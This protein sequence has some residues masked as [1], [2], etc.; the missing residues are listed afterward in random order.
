VP[1]RNYIPQT[2][3]GG[4]DLQTSPGSV[5]VTIRVQPVFSSEFNERSKENYKQNFV[6][7]VKETWENKCVLVNGPNRLKP[8]FEINFTDQEPHYIAMVD[9]NLQGQPSVSALK[10]KLSGNKVDEIPK[11]AGLPRYTYLPA[12]IVQKPD[13]AEG[14]KDGYPRDIIRSWYEGLKYFVMDTQPSLDHCA[15]SIFKEFGHNKTLGV[16]VNTNTQWF[17]KKYN[18]I[19]SRIRVETP[20]SERPIS[21]LNP[22]PY[23]IVTVKL[24]DAY[25]SDISKVGGPKNV[26]LPEY[27]RK[28]QNT[29]VPAA[30]NRET[31]CHEF[32]HMLGLPDEY[33]K[34]H[35]SA[36]TSLTFDGNFRIDF[37]E[38]MIKVNDVPASM[39]HN[40]DDNMTMQIDSQK[41]YIELCLQ[42]VGG[43]PVMGV[44][45]M[46]LMSYG[47]SVRPEH[48]V[49]LC[50][51][52]D[53]E[54]RNNNWVVVEGIR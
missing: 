1:L 40:L 54:T 38:G 33:Y 10:A 46:S 32:G 48:F 14:L 19:I 52:L 35:P 22:A 47:A 45:T 21:S 3:I 13:L 44:A 36:V 30:I 25:S 27:V 2:G 34:L 26:S 8:K 31:I 15:K 11:T 50:E 29:S 4:F 28:I 5:T 49:T 7:A 53:K 23:S 16:R 6:R 24:R 12:P 43:L 20:V 9:N 37:M 41:R 18:K 51:A 39:L 17:G 42:K